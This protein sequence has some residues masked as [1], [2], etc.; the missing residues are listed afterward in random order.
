[1]TD[2][3]QPQEEEQQEVQECSIT[4]PGGM[5]MPYIQQPP[6]DPN[7]HP[8]GGYPHQYPPNDRTNW[9]MKK[10]D[11]KDKIIENKDEIIQS[12]LK[13]VMKDQTLNNTTNEEKDQTIEKLL[14]ENNVLKT[15]KK[16]DDETIK[17]LL[18]KINLLNTANDEKNQTIQILE[19]DNTELSN[20]LKEKKLEEETNINKSYR[21]VTTSERNK[22]PDEDP[23]ED[24]EEDSENKT[25]YSVP[26][27]NFV[28]NNYKQRRSVIC[29]HWENGTCRFTANTCNFAHGDEYLGTINENK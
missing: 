9:M 23:Q 28:H 3:Q 8:Y 25:F 17:I 15:T 22:D 7:M 14:K 4:L 21:D 11:E 6:F 19:S 24:L 20:I 13:S 12:F 26:R 27:S 1:M 29:Y 2:Q 5:N 10:I 18:K 16:E